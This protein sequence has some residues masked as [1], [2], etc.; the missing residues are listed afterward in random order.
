MKL[1]FN[2]CPI[3]CFSYQFPPVYLTKTSI[4]ISPL[5]ALMEEQVE[6]L[7]KLGI[8][9]ALLGSAQQ[10]YSVYEKSQQGDYRLIYLSPE[11]LLKANGI[12]FL[13]KMKRFICLICIDEVHCVPDWGFDFR[14]SYG[15]LGELKRKFRDIPMLAVTA[16]ATVSAQQTI[17]DLLELQSPYIMKT[18]FDR[19]NLCLSV[20][21]KTDVESDLLPL[22]N[23]NTNKVILYVPTRAQAE[24]ISA[25]LNANS[26][27]SVAYHAGM[28]LAERRLVRNQFDNGSVRIVVATIAFGN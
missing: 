8:P 10:N 21:I 5:I 7:T 4:V 11:Y 14:L 12:E 6:T 9:A 27:P 2:T 16:T 22:L 26:I 1:N 23:K 25:L 15:E 3:D 18:T 24:K 28:E 17:V 19:P 13:L 20:K